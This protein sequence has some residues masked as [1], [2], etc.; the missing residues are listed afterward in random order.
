MNPFT[1]LIA[2]INEDFEFGDRISLHC[3]KYVDIPFIP[4]VPFIPDRVR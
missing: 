1:M 4:D 2:F 3:N